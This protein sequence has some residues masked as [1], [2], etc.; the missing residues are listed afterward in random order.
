MNES[1]E[2]VA[3]SSDFLRVEVESAL[4]NRE[5]PLEALIHDRT[6]YAVIDG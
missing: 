4:R 2:G 6:R 3:S 5:L 1:I